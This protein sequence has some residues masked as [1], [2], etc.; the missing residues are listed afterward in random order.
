[1][2]AIALGSQTATKISKLET[3]DSASAATAQPSL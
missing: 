2:D 1:V 3:R